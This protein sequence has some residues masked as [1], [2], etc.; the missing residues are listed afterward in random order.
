MKAIIITIII[1]NKVLNKEK[2]GKNL[3][4]KNRESFIGKMMIEGRL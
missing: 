2:R 1:T 3:L 4:K